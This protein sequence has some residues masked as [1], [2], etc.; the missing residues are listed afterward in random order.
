MR[1]F[2]SLTIPCTYNHNTFGEI[3]A[4]LTGL[5]SSEDSIKTPFD[6]HFDSAPT[7]YVHGNPSQTSSETRTLEQAIASLTATNPYTGA[8]DKVT[9]YLADQTEMNILHMVTADPQRTPTFTM[10]GDPNYYFTAG[11]PAKYDNY[12][13]YLGP[14][15][16]TCFDGYYAWNHGDV[17]PQI[18]TTWLGLVGPGV[19]HIGVDNT[20]WSDHTDIRPTMMLLLGLKDDY[21]HEGVALV[22]YLQNSAIPQ[23]LRGNGNTYLALTQV[24]KEINAPVGPLGLKALTI[25]TAALS[26][27]NPTTYSNL[28][29]ELSAILTARNHLASQMIPLLEGA[30]FSGQHI[31]PK[32]ADSLVDQANALLS[33]VSADAQSATS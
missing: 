21:T 2:A 17:Q 8:T 32:Q 14:G 29:N 28:E 12:C 26:T 27:T 25:S 4:Y 31:N 9:Q 13:N 30:E 15:V 5:L 20:L 19:K 22:P 18:V 1:E 3:D 6:V 10:F 24:Y 23:S 33:L 16:N 7:V 11:T